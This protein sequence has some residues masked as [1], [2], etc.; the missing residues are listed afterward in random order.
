VIGRQ[1]RERAHHEI[2][3]DLRHRVQG[4]HT[5]TH[6]TRHSGRVLPSL[7]GVRGYSRCLRRCLLRTR[8]PLFW[9]EVGWWC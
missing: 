5:H 2:C 8:A 4:K 6:L 1:A 7:S 9:V 3:S